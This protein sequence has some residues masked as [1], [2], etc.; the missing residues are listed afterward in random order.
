MKELKSA[1]IRQDPRSVFHRLPP[2]QDRYGLKIR[3]FI[4]AG[5]GNPAK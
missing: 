3:F 1:S 4:Y 5:F 2:E